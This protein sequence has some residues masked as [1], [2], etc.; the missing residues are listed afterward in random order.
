MEKL[1]LEE[2]NELR[3]KNNKPVLHQFLE[4]KIAEREKKRQKLIFDPNR[5]K[6]IKKLEEDLKNQLLQAQE[7]RR[8]L[9][10]Q[11]QEGEKQ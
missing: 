6:K 8:L 9:D 1:T 7:E 10:E 2:R 3:Q 11:I 5:Q 4:S